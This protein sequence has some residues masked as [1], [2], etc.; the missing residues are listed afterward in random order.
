MRGTEFLAYRILLPF[1]WADR[2]MLFT[3]WNRVSRWVKTVSYFG[4]FEAKLFAR[5]LAVEFKRRVPWLR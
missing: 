5:S 4:A 3:R 2:K 1:E